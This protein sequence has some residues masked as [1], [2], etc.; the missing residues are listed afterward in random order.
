MLWIGIQSRFFEGYISWLPNIAEALVSR[1]VD[2]GSFGQLVVGILSAGGFAYLRRNRQDK[3][4][5]VYSRVILGTLVGGLAVQL[6]LYFILEA[7]KAKVSQVYGE[8]LAVA[9]ID[10]R[11]TSIA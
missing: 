9:L 1:K 5:A 10:W 6:V 3:T 2:F 8:Q 11:S 4:A 7:Q